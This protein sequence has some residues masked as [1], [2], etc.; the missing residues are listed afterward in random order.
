MLFR[1][2]FPALLACLLNTAIT[3]AAPPTPLETLKGPINHVI[4]ILNDTSAGDPAQKQKQGIQ[5]W[6][7]LRPFFD[8]YE[9]SRLA[10][11]TQRWQGFSSDEKTQFQDVLSKFL[12]NT[13]LDK[14]QGD[15]GKV[16]IIFVSEMIRDNRALARTKLV[17][18]SLELTIG[19][20]MHNVE[21]QWKVYDLLV[22]DADIKF[23]LKSD[24]QALFSSSFKNESPAELIDVLKQKVKEQNG[25]I[26]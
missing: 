15:F 14:I 25:V 11:G 20:L 22:E 13:Y 19:Y 1:W 16:N 10:L 23:R 7:T 21:G 26:K 12:A 2:L 24:Y 5:I 9:L 17:A 8:F 4:Q 6:E 18:E 3:F